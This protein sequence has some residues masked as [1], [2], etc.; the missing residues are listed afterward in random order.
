MVIYI[1]GLDFKQI[2]GLNV[3][4]YK[5]D[6]YQVLRQIYVDFKENIDEIKPK[7]FY[8]KK[9]HFKTIEILVSRVTS[10][11]CYTLRYIPL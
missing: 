4:E 11:T 2:C 7:N 3:I 8:E 9:D 5:S 1:K 10:M 6:K